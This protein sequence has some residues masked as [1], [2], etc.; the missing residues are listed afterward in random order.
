[1]ALGRMERE[2]KEVK[3]SLDQ[4]TKNNEEIKS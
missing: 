1:V 2:R 4:I 3:E